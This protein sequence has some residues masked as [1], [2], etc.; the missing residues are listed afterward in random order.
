MITQLQLKNFTAFTEL[1]IDFSPGINIIIGENGTGKTQ[2]LKAIRALSGA[3]AHGENAD[4]QLAQKLCR[5][6][7]P[8]SEKVGGLRRSGSR[9]KALLSANFNSGRDVTAAFGGSDTAVRITSNGNITPAEALFIPTKEVL[10]LARGLNS[11]KADDETIN[12][13]FDDSYIDLAK[14]LFNRVEGNLSK[15]IQEDPRLSSIVPRITKL[16][17]GRYIL[18]KGHI[19]FQAGQYEEKVGQSVQNEETSAQVFKSSK[20]QF[21]PSESALV[22]S[23]M[24]AEGF[25]KIGM[26][27]RL[28]S[29][30]SLNPG[31]TGPLLWDEPESNLN[32]KLM[33]DLVQALLELARN[34]QQVILAT[35]DYVL[36]KWFDLLMDKGK[37]DQVRFHVLSR[38]ADTGQVRR[39]S[40]DDYR[41][42]EPN[43]IA[44][45]FNELTKE[46][47]ARKMGGLG[48]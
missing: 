5:L 45:T 34:G 11:G 23:A 15:R 6:Y 32:P 26:L 19:C 40:M 13:I 42:I 22:S 37:G 10:S 48:K 44:E 18:K 31:T 35:H 30:G 12:L 28:L 29:N 36:L 20:I 16:I 24:T 39:D 46:Q 8:L 1:A 25:R 14:L 27:Q 38:D 7:L 33:R 2:L 4:E 47:V 17:G 41:A 21:T 9:R 3:W 43:A